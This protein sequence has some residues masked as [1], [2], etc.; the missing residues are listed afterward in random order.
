M[1][2]I[3]IYR[4]HIY[5]HYLERERER[6]YTV[7]PP[8]NYSKYPPSC[9]LALFWVNDFP[10]FPEVLSEVTRFGVDPPGVEVVY[11]K[12]WWVGWYREMVQPS[13]NWQMV[14]YAKICEVL[15]FFKLV[16]QRVRCCKLLVFP[17]DLQFLFPCGY[18]SHVSPHLSSPVQCLDFFLDFSQLFGCSLWTFE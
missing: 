12:M 15:L 10:A 3:Y 13:W 6:E 2:Y 11:G 16:C 17:R 8:D 4:I 5:T 1:I 14:I 18:L 7:Y 9:C